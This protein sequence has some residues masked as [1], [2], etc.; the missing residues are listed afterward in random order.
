MTWTPA[1]L[2]HT[3]TLA[4]GSNVPG[5]APKTGMNSRGGLLAPEKAIR[6]DIDVKPGERILVLGEG[7][8]SYEALLV[9]EAIQRKG[10][11]AAV[12]CITRSL[13]LVEAAL[14]PYTTLTDHSCRG[15]PCLLQNTSG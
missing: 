10:G 13:A 15:Q 4:A 11:V 12:Q 5:R 7:E 2:T 6:A 9:A 1:E 8:H 14:R 3:P